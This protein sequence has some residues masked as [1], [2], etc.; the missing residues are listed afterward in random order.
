MI[1]NNTEEIIAVRVMDRREENR[2]KYPWAA[3]FV[4]AVRERWPAAKV[5]YLG[6]RREE[7]DFMA[8]RR[9]DSGD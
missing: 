6:E 9:E 1:A 8:D 4:D 7:Y 2:K 3:D 5:K